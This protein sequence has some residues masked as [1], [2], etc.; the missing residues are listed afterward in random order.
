[1]NGLFSVGT[2]SLPYPNAFNVSFRT[3]S[4][5]KIPSILFCTFPGVKSRALVASLLSSTKH[6]REKKYK[7]DNAIRR[8]RDKESVFSNTFT[9]NQWKK[10]EKNA[11][12]S[13]FMRFS[14]HICRYAVVAY[15]LHHSLFLSFSLSL[16]HKHTL[17]IPDIVHLSRNRTHP[18]THST[19]FRRHIVPFF[20]TR[21]RS[22]HKRKLNTHTD[23]SMHSSVIGINGEV[24]K[25]KKRHSLGWEQ[26]KETAIGELCGEAE[27]K[28]RSRCTK[29]YVIVAV[30][31]VLI[32]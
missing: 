9:Q 4:W 16:M 10:S 23:V 19:I 11:T 5:Q 13:E 7:P 30:W 32:E 20:R 22:T 1:M 27:K 26:K 8:E 2:K 25:K 15:I 24:S 21:F 28:K 14:I 6:R 12:N 31:L 17:E 3:R 18:Y 29:I